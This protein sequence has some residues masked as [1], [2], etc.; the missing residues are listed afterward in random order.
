LLLTL[1]LMPAGLLVTCPAPVPAS[2]TVR[3]AIGLKVAVIV[4]FAV[5]VMMQVLVPLH[6]PPLQP[7]K[8]DPA[9][10]EAVRVTCVPTANGA[11]H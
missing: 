8:V 10:A 3:V 9:A 5:G 1:Q 6:P 2:T 4:V 11:V 7:A